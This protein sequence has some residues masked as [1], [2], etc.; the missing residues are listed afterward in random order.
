[1]RF[2]LAIALLATV[3]ATAAGTTAAP[4]RAGLTCGVAAEQ[5]FLRWLDATP[6]RL[7]TSGS[8][9]SPDGWTLSGGASVVPGNEPFFL[10]SRQ[11]K[12]SL[13]LPP[14][15]SATSPWTCASV[16]GLVARLLAVSGGSPLATLQVDLL[17]KT[18]RGKTRT[19]G[20]SAIP[21]A[22]HGSWAPTAPI[23]IAPG[24]ILSDAADFD[25][26]TTEVAFR[27]RPSSGLLTSATWRIDD[28]YVDPWVDKL[29]W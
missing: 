20:L 3:A 22:L 14:G 4:A 19:I 25:L 8:F 24:T 5:V 28:L 16:D 17:Y 27:F 6:Y 12:H 23:L 26:G 11:D 7:A 21:A 1:M 15:S 2:R 13:S 9:E 29:G 18:A 10:N